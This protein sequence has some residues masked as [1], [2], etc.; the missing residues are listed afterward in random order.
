M[1]SEKKSKGYDI[2]KIH[3]LID[4]ITFPTERRTS[5]T[6]LETTRKLRKKKIIR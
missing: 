2:E 4:G 1:V 3:E 6:Y 5:S